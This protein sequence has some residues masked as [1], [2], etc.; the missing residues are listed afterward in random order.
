MPMVLPRAWFDSR[1]MPFDSK[2]VQVFL[3]D[4]S[5]FICERVAAALTDAGLLVVGQ[6]AT[7]DT[8]IQ[9][10]LQTRPDAVVLD[11]RLRGGSGLQVMQAVRPVAPQIAFV[12]FSDNAAD[13]YR[14]RYLREGASAFLEKGIELTRLAET[15][16]L[17]ARATR[18]H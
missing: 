16:S 7:P 15:V 9:G 8:C 5:P 14:Q 10:I 18:T 4:D 1:V 6:A 12:V 13:A 2:A 11:V 17:A 3:A